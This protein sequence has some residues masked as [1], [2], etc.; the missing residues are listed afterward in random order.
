MCHFSRPMNICEQ[1][2]AFRLLLLM[3]V[4]DKSEI[5]AWADGIIATQDT[6][7]EWLLDVSLAANEDKWAIEGKLREVRGEASPV[8]AAYAAIERFAKEF[9]ISGRFKPEQAAQMLVVWAGSAKV[10]QDDRTAAMVP[11]WVADAVPD[12]YTSHQGVVESINNCIARFAAIRA[13][14]GV[15]ATSQILGRSDGRG[16]K[17]EVISDVPVSPLSY[18]TAAATHTAYRVAV[19]G[20]WLIPTLLQ[21]IGWIAFFPF[22]DD[23]PEVYARN[24]L[25]GISGFSLFGA[26]VLGLVT[27]NS[28]PQY[29]AVAVASWVVVLSV[30]CMR[31]ARRLPVALHVALAVFWNIVGLFL[32][33]VMCH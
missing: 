26:S 3:E 20:A 16:A 9:H 30:A 14:N 18:A 28:L 24:I 31:W 8:V 22:G 29:L 27:P 32:Y 1:A 25:A 11:S 13:A 12:G 10:S 23:G 4:I 5:I 33:A 15:S 21:A 7:P 19:V 17:C 6:L 2:E